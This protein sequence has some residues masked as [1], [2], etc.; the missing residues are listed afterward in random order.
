[1]RVQFGKTYIFIQ[2]LYVMG[3]NMEKWHLGPNQRRIL[4]LLK[5][6]D[7]TI[8]EIAAELYGKKINLGEHEYVATSKSLRSLLKRGLLTKTTPETR[9][10]IKRTK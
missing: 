2:A 3:E 4:E 10:S 9:Y 5:K 6:K 1:M 7:M 8:R